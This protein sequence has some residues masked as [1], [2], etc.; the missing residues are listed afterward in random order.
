LLILPLPGVAAHE[1]RLFSPNPATKLNA[2]SGYVNRRFSKPYWSYFILYLFN[3]S[4]I[5]LF[6]SKGFTC[7]VVFVIC[8]IYPTDSYDERL[9]SLAALTVAMT[10]TV[11]LLHLYEFEHLQLTLLRNL[12]FTLSQRFVQYSLLFGLLLLPEALF[13]LRYLPQEV[14][15]VYALGWWG[16]LLAMFWLIYGRFLQKHYIMDTLMRQGFYVFLSF[17]FLIMFRVP[18]IILIISTLFV[19]IYLFNRYYY[20]SEY[21]VHQEGL[22][23]RPED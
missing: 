23:L 15:V 10:H 21:I 20:L 19:G 13:L 11:M 12:P 4:P 17:F 14:S 18:L 7:F 2:L 9:L 3:Q 16:F 5:L 6:L 1:S 8:K 22:H